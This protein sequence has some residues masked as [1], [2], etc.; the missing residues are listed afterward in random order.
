MIKRSSALVFCPA[1]LTV[2]IV[3]ANILVEPSVR[4]RSNIELDMIF[5]YININVNVFKYVHFCAEYKA[6]LYI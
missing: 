6:P 3:L 2:R 1:L 4:V 5:K